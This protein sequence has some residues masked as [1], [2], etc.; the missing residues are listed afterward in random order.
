MKPNTYCVVRGDKYRVY[1]ERRMVDQ[2]NLI[3]EPGMGPNQA[4]R[5][6]DVLRL[7]HEIGKPGGGSAVVLQVIEGGKV[8]EVVSFSKWTPPT[9]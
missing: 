6:S 5:M 1:R 7:G 3:H 8:A 4:T 9:I 2:G